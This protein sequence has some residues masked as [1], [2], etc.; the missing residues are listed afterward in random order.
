MQSKAKSRAKSKAK[1]KGGANKASSNMNLPGATGTSNVADSSSSEERSPMWETGA[2]SKRVNFLGA[3]RKATVFKYPTLGM[4]HEAVE[5]LP[6]EEV[7]EQVSRAC[8]AKASESSHVLK[9]IL[10]KSK[11]DHS[12]N[13][14]ERCIADTGCS[15]SI[16]NSQIVQKLGL[17]VR[18][19]KQL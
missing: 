18:P 15:F 16:I 8:A 10:Y 12:V 7:R 3:A 14:K 19:Y 2:R 6:V 17:K 9:G 1:K 11:N 5:E 13:S 4:I